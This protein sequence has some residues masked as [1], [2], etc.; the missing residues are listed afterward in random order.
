[1]ARH[2]GEMINEISLAMTAGLGLKV[3]GKTVH[4]YPTRSEVIKKAAD[5]YNKT[6]LT[7]FIKKLSCSWLKWQRR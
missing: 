2:A 7:P 4:P 6:R 3:I 5:I 1:V